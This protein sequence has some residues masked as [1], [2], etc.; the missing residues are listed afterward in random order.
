MVISCKLDL[1]G[2]LSQSVRRRG[3][4]GVLMKDAAHFLFDRGCPHE[5]EEEEERLA[6]FRP[7]PL[8][9]P[10]TSSHVSC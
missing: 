5:E 2:I 3:G 1:A 6:S 4:G 9:A 8:N 10:R 7:K